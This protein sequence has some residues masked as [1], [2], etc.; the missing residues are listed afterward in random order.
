M[1]ILD[2]Q[3]TDAENKIDIDPQEA[4]EGKHVELKERIE[5]EEDEELINAQESRESLVTGSA[6]NQRPDRVRDDQSETAR[7]DTA[8]DRLFVDILSLARPPRPPRP[9]PSHHHQHHGGQQQHNTQP[10]KYNDTRDIVT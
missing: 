6:A 10:G 4:R 3:E 1:G 7:E 9:P 8:Q 5:L 2:V